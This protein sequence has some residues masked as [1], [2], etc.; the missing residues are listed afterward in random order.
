VT[1]A[2]GEDVIV[3]LPDSVPLGVAEEVPVEEGVALPVGV[4]PV[5][6]CVGVED[7]VG[8]AVAQRERVLV[9]VWVG[10]VLEA[11][12]ADAVAVEVALAPAPGLGV[13]RWNRGAESPC[14]G[15]R[16][17]DRCP[18]APLDAHLLASSRKRRPM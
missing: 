7:C 16:P 8:V 6:H 3:E 11:A 4:P 18:S 2:V 17:S 1:E 10:E 13:G 12:V 14:E 9:E 15:E 5:A